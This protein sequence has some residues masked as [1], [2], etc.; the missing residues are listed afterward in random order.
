MGGGGTIFTSPD[1]ENW[2]SADSNNTSF[3][4]DVTFH[5]GVYVAVGRDFDL[6][7]GVVLTS[8]TGREW[9]V[10][11]NDD[12]RLVLS[13]ASSPD[14]LA[15]TGLGGI[16]LTSPDAVI[17]TQR[18]SGIHEEMHD[19]AL[20]NDTLAA[21]GNNGTILTSSDGVT[22]LVRE[23]QNTNNLW[24]IAYGAGYLLR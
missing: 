18:S 1:G 8:S 17:W 14:L 15:A 21:V 5:N 2:S 19:I 24:G 10:L 16:I 20:G 12:L 7:T 9:E 23:S 11:F 4:E 22:W 3:L 13:V 6:D